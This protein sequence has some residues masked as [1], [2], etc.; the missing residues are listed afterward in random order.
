MHTVTTGTTPSIKVERL[1][2]LMTVQNL[3]ELTVTE[4]NATAHETVRAMT[5][6]FL[7]AL[8]QVWSE[9]SRSKLTD[10]LV[11]VNWQKLTSLIHASRHVERSN[12]LADGLRGRRLLSEAQRGKRRWL[13][14]FVRHFYA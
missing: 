4:D 12:N 5:R 10:E 6:Y 2:L 13:S 14:R 3:V 7:E 11:I 1:A 9:R 8:E